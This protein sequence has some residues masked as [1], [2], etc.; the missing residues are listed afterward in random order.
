M[1]FTQTFLIALQSL[2]GNKLRSSLTILGIVIGVAAV[3]AMLGIGRGA[4]AG[5]TASVTQNGT[6]LLYVRPGAAQSSGGVRSAAGSSASLTLDDAAALRGV[7]GVAAVAPEVDGRGQLVYQGANANTSIV[8]TTPDYLTARSMA[9]AYGDFFSDSQVSARSLVAVLG[10]TVATTLFGDPASAVGQ[11]I[12]VGS[13]GIPVKVIG[14][15]V[16]KGGSGFGNQDD[17]IFVPITTAQTRLIGST[18][19]GASTSVQTINVQVANASAIPQV[20]S[21]MT[22]LLDQRHKVLS[23]AEDFTIQNQADILSTLSSVANTLTLFLGGI[24]GISLLVGGI[25]VMNI[26]LVSV[27]ERT[28]EIGIR[29]A[30][31]ARRNDILSQFMIESAALSLLGGL[32]GIALGWGIAASMGKVQL[33]GSAIT[34]VVGL[35]SMLLATLFSAA[36]GLFFGIYP[37]MRAAALAP[38]EALRYE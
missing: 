9:V 14:V 20:T 12:K 10:P 23:G 6:N 11:T 32:L 18:R 22:A 3:V 24:A 8:G 36:I 29:K 33:G 25:G 30:L 37:A 1:N 17:A 4:Q 28:R 27:T 26:M 35:D 31:G 34:P 21:D 16:A 13:S 38:V 2:S 15:T 7:A 19:S 5:I